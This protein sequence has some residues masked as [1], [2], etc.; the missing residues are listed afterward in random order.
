MTLCVSFSALK[1][2]LFVLENDILLF[3]IPS[4]FLIIYLFL[5]F[6]SSFYFLSHVELRRLRNLGLLVN[7]VKVQC[8]VYRRM[9]SFFAL[10]DAQG[11]M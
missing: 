10:P 3:L 9:L 7:Q 6:P 2:W 4:S 11:T 8:K 1:Y 5:F